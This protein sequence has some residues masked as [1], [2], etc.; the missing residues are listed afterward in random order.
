MRTP[1]FE[2]TFLPNLLQVVALECKREI[3][4]CYA[5]YIHCYMLHLFDLYNTLR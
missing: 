2:T 1:E 4:M 3:T 5:E